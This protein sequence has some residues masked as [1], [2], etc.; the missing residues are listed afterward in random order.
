MQRFGV[1][2]ELR[3][4]D[5]AEQHVTIVPSLLIA[6][7]LLGDKPLPHAKFSLLSWNARWEAIVSTDAAGVF[8]DELWETGSFAN[9][10]VENRELTPG[11]E[12]KLDFVIPDHRVAVEV[13]DG[14]GKPVPH[15]WVWCEQFLTDRKQGVGAGYT[16]DSGRITFGPA[17]VGRSMI[18]VR[19]EGIPEPTPLAFDIIESEREK[20]VRVVLNDG[21]A[22]TLTVVDARN[23][24][25]AGASVII[26]AINGVVPLGVTANDGTL[27]IGLADP[28]HG[29]LFVIPRGS[30]FGFLRLATVD[31]D[32]P[33]IVVADGGAALQVTTLD[34]SGAPIPNVS[35]LF[36]WNGMLLPLEVQQELERVQGLAFRTNADGVAWLSNLPPGFVELWPLTSRAELDRVLSLAPPEPAASVQ[37]NRGRQ[38]VVMKFSPGRASP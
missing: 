7:V 38:N 24:P 11:A 8:R 17:R 22:R 21:E 36:Q 28:R 32:E 34:T 37:L 20:S 33:K 29:T 3:D 2:F 10:Y 19:K 18:H 1:L 9:V 6:R 15:A 13:V 14:S 23:Q 5:A 26:A 25:V 35:F 30:G 12:I 4:G 27:R 31:G 16:D